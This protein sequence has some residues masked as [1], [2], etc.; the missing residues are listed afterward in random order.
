MIGAGTSLEVQNPVAFQYE[1]PSELF[2]YFPVRAP[3]VA[4]DR[5]LVAGVRRTAEIPAGAEGEGEEAGG[6]GAAMRTAGQGQGRARTGRTLPLMVRKVGS[7]GRRG[8]APCGAAA[9]AYEKEMAKAAPAAEG[10]STAG[11]NEYPDEAALIAAAGF[12]VA[13]E[14]LIATAKEFLDSNNGIDKR[15]LF[16][17]DFQFAGPV[18]GPIDEDTFAKAFSSFKITDAFPDAKVQNYHFRV[19]PFE[20]NRVCFTTK[21]KGTNTG[22]FAGTIPA[23]GIVVDSP[24]QTC[25]LVF[26][27]EGKVKKFTIGYVMD[28]DQGNTG[29]LGG[30]YGL[31]Y[32]I[33][34]PLP[35]PEAQPWKMS[36]RYKLFQAIGRITS[37][38]G[39]RD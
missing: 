26:N 39:N 21:F 14:T 12:P 31:L 25:T 11:F 17:A 24:P 7:V 23:T 18:V 4:L 38:F 28:R 36:K 3:S 15:E 5:E 19:D 30:A 10:G 32:A 9:E 8:P 27:E 6:S 22:K 16:A 13:P 1:V 33:G 34:K 2:S 37:R 35:F 20:P 29:G